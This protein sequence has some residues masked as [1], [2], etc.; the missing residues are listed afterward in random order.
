MEFQR[1]AV[2]AVVSQG[3]GNGLKIG[4]VPHNGNLW[5]KPVASL[6]VSAVLSN[7]FVARIAGNCLKRAIYMDEPLLRITGV[8]NEHSFINFF[9]YRANSFG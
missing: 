9:D 5:L 3:G 2:L 1:G 6:Q 4:I 7:S 8:R